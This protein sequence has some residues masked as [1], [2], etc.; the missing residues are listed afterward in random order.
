MLAFT[1]INSIATDITSAALTSTATSAA[2]TPTASGS[3]EFNVIVTA[4]SGTNPTLDVVV[5]ESDDS[6]T[7]WFDIYQFPRITATGQYRSPLIPMV[8]NRVRYVRTV[9]GTTPS[10]TNSVNRLIVNT[11]QPL[12]RQFFDR[13]VVPNT[14]NSTSPSFFT[15]GCVDL[16]V[17]VNMGAIT[18]TAPT[19]ALQVSVD[20]VNF[21]Q[22]GADIVTVANT[23]NILQVSNAQARF[24]RL[25][26]KSAG[27]GA[28]LGYVMVKGVG[29]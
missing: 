5:Q 12:Q 13:T 29:N 27:S 9:G 2:F 4:V 3:A 25:L 23:T 15:E 22:L 24:S 20:N 16:V 18:T 1:P 10:F 8:G 14:L 26:V 6:G 28:T 21:V 7:N 11:A 19:F 17:L